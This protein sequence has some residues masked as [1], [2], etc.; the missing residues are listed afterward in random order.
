MSNFL[1]YHTEIILRR[2]KYWIVTKN[3]KPYTGS[4]IHLLLLHKSHIEHISDLKKEAWYELLSHVT[5]ASK[6]FKLKGETLLMR[7]GNTRYNGASV[8]H[9]HAQIISG[10]ARTVKNAKPIRTVVGFGKQKKK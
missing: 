2:G 1:T 10:V 7:Y 5:W 4:K 3:F 9:L 6:K 8:N